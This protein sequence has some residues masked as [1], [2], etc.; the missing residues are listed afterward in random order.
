MDVYT[1]RNKYACTVECIFLSTF[2]STGS[3]HPFY[4][5]L[6]PS[7]FCIE[8]KNFSIFI[9]SY[10]KFFYT[11]LHIQYSCKLILMSISPASSSSA[12]SMAIKTDEH[13]RLYSITEHC[14]ILKCTHWNLLKALYANRIA[15]YR[16]GLKF[17]RFSPKRT[18][19]KCWNFFI[20]LSAA[21]YRVVTV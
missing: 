10:F 4:T 5:Q 15:P 14:S 17:W 7:S 20:H 3:N 21:L 9:M 19:K 16:N 18:R 13:W 8:K 2:E 1:I 6:S 11:D 12:L